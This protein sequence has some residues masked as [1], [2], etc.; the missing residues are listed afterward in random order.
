VAIQSAHK[1]WQ[2][3]KTDIV[4]AKNVHLYTYANVTHITADENVKQI[5]EVTIKNLAGKTHR[6]RAKHFVLACCSI[7]NARLLLASNQQAKKGLGNDNDNVG[8]YFMEHLE[9]KSAE[10]H[11]F[12]P[13]H[14][15]LYSWE[16][17]RKARAELAIHPAMQEKHKILNGTASLERLDIANK[18]KPV[19]E[20][21]NDTD[22]RKSMKQAMEGFDGAAGLQIDPSKGVDAYQLFTRIEQAP[23]PDSRVT[24][25]VE[26]DALG[27]PRA[28]LHWVLTP[29]EKRSMRV[30]YTLIGEQIGKA[31]LG[32][33]RLMEYLQDEK[34]DSWPN[35]TGGGWHHMGTTRMNED[36]KQGVVDANCKVHG[37]SNLHIAGASCYATAA[38][39]NPTLTL[40]ALTIRLSDHLKETMKNKA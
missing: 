5:T 20:T 7:Q 6:V 31:G 28:Q 25:D 38:A 23:N 21:F 2:Q 39:P 16:F 14:S 29:A 26:K 3:Y 34:D 1:I 4:N 15:D 17:G 30:I 27:V 40:V 36:P 22:A 32:R 11:L 24:L 33:V 37:I 13:F 10:I 8:R 9:I 18:I 19:I 12:K 35:F